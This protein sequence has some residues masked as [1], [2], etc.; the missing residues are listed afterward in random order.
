MMHEIKVKNLAVKGTLKLTNPLNLLLLSQNFI[1]NFNLAVY[2]T[3]RVF[4]LFT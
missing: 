1:L 3:N 4:P 2:F